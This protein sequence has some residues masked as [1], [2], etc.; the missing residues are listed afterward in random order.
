M[1]QLY[2]VFQRIAAELDV[3]V[4]T[5]EARRTKVR[6]KLECENLFELMVLVL[7][8]E[9]WRVALPH[10]EQEHQPELPG[11]SFHNVAPKNLFS[12]PEA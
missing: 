2:G 1:K 8:Y 7:S 4:K 6:E 5:V 9:A 3:S 11:W 10:W 12:E